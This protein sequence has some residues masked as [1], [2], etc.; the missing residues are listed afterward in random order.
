MK[1]TLTHPNPYRYLEAPPEIIVQL[2]ALG[3]TDDPTAAAAWIRSLPRA[4]FESAQELWEARPP[5]ALQG[6]QAIESSLLAF[7]VAT[8][9]AI[10]A[11]AQMGESLASWLL[12]WTLFCLGFSLLGMAGKAKR[13]ESWRADY[14]ARLDRLTAPPKI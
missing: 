9:L 14:F 3:G 12:H 7:F 4:A 10:F 13:R 6:L 8:L 1:K 2:K 11:G 5:D